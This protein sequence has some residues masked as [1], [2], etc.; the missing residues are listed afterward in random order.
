MG[1]SLISVTTCVPFFFII[2]LES[3]LVSKNYLKVTASVFQLQSVG[4]NFLETG[5]P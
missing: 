2:P 5:L 4:V 1:V 3:G